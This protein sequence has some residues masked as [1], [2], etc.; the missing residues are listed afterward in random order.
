LWLGI[1]LSVVGVVSQNT[2]INQVA[3]PA[4]FPENAQKII[5]M[6]K[7]VSWIMNIA[8]VGIHYWIIRKLSEEKVV[9]EFNKKLS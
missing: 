3:N 1:V 8:L 9:E 7:I 5:G 4:A 6:M 2:F